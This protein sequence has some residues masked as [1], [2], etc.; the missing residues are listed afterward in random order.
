MTSTE[1][2]KKVTNLGSP[3]VLLAGDFMLDSYLYGDALRISP[4]A[5]VQVLK[6]MDRQYCA[7][8][9]AS[10]AA[11][12]IALG[13]RC[14]CVGVSGEDAEGRRLLGLLEEMGA[15][16]GGLL[17]LADRPT[18]HKQRVIGLAQHRH[19]QQLL[20]IDEECTSPLSAAQYDG[21]F[22]L[23]KAGLEQCD[24]VCLQ[25]YNKG[26]LEPAFCRRLIGAARAAGRKVLVD[27][28]L[29][30][31][32]S[33]FRGAWMITPNRKEASEA[34]GFS[35][36]TIEEAGRAAEILRET[37]DLGAV[38]IT[39]D[40]EGAYLRTAETAEHLPTI[41]RTVYDVTGAGDMMLAMLAAATAAGCDERTAVQLANIAGGIEVEKF[42]VATVRIDEMV[43]EIISRNKGKTGKIREE[44][45]VL[46]DEL[47]YHRMQ[48]E[49]IVFTN[50]CFDV[51]HRGH[52]EYLRFCR[53]QG[54]V[55][56]VGLNSD[57][58]VRQIKGPERPINNQH[59]RASVLAA[60]ES[61]DYIVFFDEPDPLKLIE[62]VRP[63]V[64]VKGADWAEKGVVGRDFV[65]S[66]GGR[67]ELAPLVEGKSSTDVINKMRQGNS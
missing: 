1:L 47:N 8:G 26:V 12:I 20:R 19:R 41:A 38:V 18:I 25:D 24:I 33:K 54:Q 2:L 21:L 63:D 42:G 9:A 66:Y 14:I 13:G 6:V 35:I 67:V 43:N 53:Q 48:K 5:P 49:K 11:D 60:L 62:Q 27:P 37:L 51:L 30:H 45:P 3:A 59:D 23:F 22:E 56:V 61:V 44:L 4:E 64:L 7:G 28:P 36:E 40:K 57:R 55:V 34:V 46:L 32:Y 58:S 31:D 52:I 17:R 65:E 29:N 50:G 16:C 15:D 39:L 10:V